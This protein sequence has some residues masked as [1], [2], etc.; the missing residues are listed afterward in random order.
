MNII[1]IILTGCCFFF[2]GFN[3]AQ[4][5]EVNSGK[6]K[7]GLQ[8]GAIS[9]SVVNGINP[10]LNWIVEKNKHKYSFGALAVKGTFINYFFSSPFR[11]NGLQFA[12]EFDPYEKGRRVE[13]YF[14]Y[15][16]DFFHLKAKVEAS[17]VSSEIATKHTFGYVNTV[18]SGFRINLSKQW[19]LNNCFGFGPQFIHSFARFDTQE[20]TYYSNS[21][22][23]LTYACSVGFRLK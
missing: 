19:Y 8:L 7:F 1:K 11:L 14:F 6:A 15:R 21:T 5:H 20:D 16:F 18:G 22:L 13:F 4:E 10:S 23:G 2:T 17:G 9:G 3:F 12:Y